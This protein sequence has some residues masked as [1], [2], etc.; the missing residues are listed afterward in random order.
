MAQ[1]GSYDKLMVDLLATLEQPKTAVKEAVSQDFSAGRVSKL[2][3]IQ[4]IKE[5]KKEGNDHSAMDTNQAVARN[6]DFVPVSEAQVTGETSFESVFEMINEIESYL[7][8]ER[9]SVLG[10]IDGQVES[11]RAIATLLRDAYRQARA[12]VS[13]LKGACEDLEHF[14]K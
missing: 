3:G 10:V 4:Q 6:Q 1:G 14:L 12:A 8:A 11:N 5:K 7:I 9:E 2:S 13:E